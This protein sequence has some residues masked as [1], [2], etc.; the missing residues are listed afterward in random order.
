M[1]TL[2]GE[3]AITEKVLQRP[4]LGALPEILGER[5]GRVLSEPASF[6]MRLGHR[7]KCTGELGNKGGDA[8]HW[9]S[10]LHVIS[11]GEGT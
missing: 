11:E 2:A 8:W 7:A 5:S 6:C 1:R 4:S 9:S 3:L 10:A